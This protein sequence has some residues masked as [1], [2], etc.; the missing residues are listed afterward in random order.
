MRHLRL[1]KYECQQFIR[2]PVFAVN[3]IFTDIT[4]ILLG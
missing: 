3:V 1:I 2:D 4:P